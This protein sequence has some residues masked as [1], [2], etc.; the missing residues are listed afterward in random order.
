MRLVFAIAIGLL[1]CRLDALPPVQVI[2][3]APGKPP[4][5]VKARREEKL[6]YLQV[7]VNQKGPFW[8]C[9]DTGAH[10]T[11]ID[12]YVVQQAGLK[13]VSG[14]AVKGAG[15]G[16]VPTQRVGALQ[17]EIGDVKLT[18]PDPMVIDLSGVPIPKWVHGLVGAEFFEA[19]VVEIDFEQNQFRF[20]DRDNFTK[21]ARASSVPLILE[22][23]RMY[24]EATIE[25]SDTQTVTHKLRIDTGSE[26]SV[27]DDVVK[28]GK[29]VRETVL[30][31]GLGEN[32]KGYSGM[33]KAVH[34]GPFTFHDVWGP[35]GPLPAIGTEMFRR[36]KVT[37][38]APH[39]MLYLEPNSHIKD[40][41]PPPS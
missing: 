34:L 20:F 25:V 15:K 13:P 30:G 6:L 8:F 38:D 14:E 1:A 21:P 33:Y 5:V 35:G 4:I 39:G 7:K 19:Y 37:F 10:H 2:T 28:G 11:V 3:P 22:N 36:F 26:D 9:V 16:E 17:M 32:F 12:P 24:M 40:A 23:H 18:V 29:N 41:F 31:N 27:S